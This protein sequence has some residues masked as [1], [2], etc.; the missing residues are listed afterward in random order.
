MKTSIQKKVKRMPKSERVKSVALKKFRPFSDVGNAK[1]L[2]DLHGPNIRYCYSSAKWLVWNGKKWTEDNTGEINRLAKD[3]VLRI[4]S[5]VPR[6]R[7][8]DERNRLGKHALRSQSDQRI[9]A[10]INV[11][12]SEPGIPVTVDELDSDSWL[13]NVANGTL[14]LKTGKLRPHRREDLLTKFVP[15]PYFPKATC[16]T[17]EAFLHRIM[18]GNE[19]SI[20]F[21]QKAVGYSLTGSGQEQ[22][23]FILHGSG[24]NGKSTFIS[25]VLALMGDYAR[26]TPTETLLTRRG[27]GITNDVARLKGARFVAAVEAEDGKQLAEAF[28]KQLTGGDKITARFL[29]REFFEFDATFKLFLA[30]NHKPKIKGTDHAIWRRIH[31]VP[32]N[33]TIPAKERDNQLGEKLRN[34]LPGILRWAVEGCLLWQKEGLGVPESV[35]EATSEYRSEMDVIGDFIEE[36]CVVDPAANTPF[37]HLYGNYI[38]WCS[39]NGQLNV[40]PAEFGQRLAEHGF[41]SDRNKKIGRF[42]VGIRL[43]SATG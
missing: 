20:T 12:K 21:L 14:E 37:R 4:W 31:L 2:V 38:T 1:T 22:V 23:M 27:N 6:T 42:R 24:A 15:V 3:T 35:R 9:N 43:S 28:I 33:L 25:T 11:A 32:F 39:E 41:D 18:E 13:L 40:S 30:V 5:V 17:W 8:D 16:P 29:Y 36:C 10:M 26:Q 19:E 7:D 34:E